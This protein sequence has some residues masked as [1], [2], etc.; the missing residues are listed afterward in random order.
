MCPRSSIHRTNGFSTAAVFPFS[1]DFLVKYRFLFS[2]LLSDAALIYQGI[3]KMCRRKH[4]NRS[5]SGSLPFSRPF[6]HENRW[7]HLFLQPS[8]S[9]LYAAPVRCIFIVLFSKTV[10]DCNKHRL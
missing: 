2:F 4:N 9:D 5:R 6:N 1:A 3:D 10:L 8:V 7:P